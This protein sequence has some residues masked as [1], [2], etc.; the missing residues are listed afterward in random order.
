MCRPGDFVGEALDVLRGD[1]LGFERPGQGL[2]VKLQPGLF[3]PFVLESLELVPRMPLGL[4][5]VH[6]R[7]QRFQLGV[8]GP[9]DE[10]VVPLVDVGRDQRRRLGVRPG[11]DEVVDPHNVVL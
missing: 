10:R 2:W 5:R 6:D 3:Q 7:D 8:G 1:A 9:E 4:G 11:D